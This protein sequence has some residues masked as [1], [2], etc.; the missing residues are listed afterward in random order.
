MKIA[1]LGLWHLGSVTAACM[2]AAGHSVTAYDPDSNTVEGL[3]AGR[4]PVA[5]PGLTELI[6]DGL[7]AGTLRVIADRAEAV[8]DADIVW[9]TFDTPVGD[10]DVADVDYVVRQVEAAF[11]HLADGA[12]VLC[13]SQLPVGSVRSLERSWAERAGKRT[14]SF[15]CAPENLR[16]GKA[17]DVFRN[18]DRVVIGV[19]DDWARAKIQS[20]LAPLTSRLEWMTVESAEMTK[21]A[22]NAF[23]ATSVAFMNELAALCER[24]GAD[25]TEVERGLKTE[26]RIGPRAYLAPGGAFAGGTLARD[27]S[28]LRA[29]GTTLHRPTPL[30]DGVMASNTAHRMWAERRLGSTIDRLA[31]SKIAIWGLTYKPGTDTLRRSSAIDLARWLV[32]QGAH[33]HVH[34]PMARDLPDD[35]RVTRHSDPLDA[36]AGALALVVATSWPCYREIE[37]E[38]L[39]SLAPDLLVLDANRFLGTTLGKDRRFRLVAVGQPE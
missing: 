13:S 21:H 35:L 9:V 23:L 24:V 17:I 8:H 28:F 3:A 18:P 19:R 31:G 16:L 2:S 30:M 11:P 26:S 39:A 5:E 1:V 15:A 25:A 14:V 20:A 12:V 34:D 29:L 33:V 32:S 4:P 7:R 6:A 38:R 36:A 37:V 10:D 22:V 27:V